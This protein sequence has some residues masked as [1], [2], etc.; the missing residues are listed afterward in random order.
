MSQDLVTIK[1]SQVTVDLHWVSARIFDVLS[2]WAGEAENPTVAVSMATTS[3]HL[4]WHVSDLAE[5]IPEPEGDDGEEAPDPLH[6]AVADALDAIQE[7]PGTV[8]RLGVAHRVLLPR[9][10]VECVKIERGS[11]PDDEPD[12]LVEIARALLGDL[13]RDR[14]DGEVI[15]ASL[16]IDIATVQRVGERMLEAER[17]IVEAGGLVPITLP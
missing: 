1:P 14:D 16:I 13:R 6:P 2:H 11:K 3:R 12:P 4:S 5:L 10:A 7:I 9:L 17:R 8:E 15:L